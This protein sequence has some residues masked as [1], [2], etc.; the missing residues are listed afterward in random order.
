MTCQY[1]KLDPH[2]AEDE[3][4][5]ADYDVMMAMIVKVTSLLADTG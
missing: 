1:H 3:D 4:A 5:A 2:G